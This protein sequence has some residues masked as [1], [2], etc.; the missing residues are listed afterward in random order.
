MRYY[1]YIVRC[2]GGS[3][4]TGITTDPQRR[5]R[6]HVLHLAP[7]AKYTKSHQVIALDAL[8]SAETRSEASMLEAA[9]K[10]LR[11]EKKRQLIE[12]PERLAVF[13]GARLDTSIYRAEATFSLAPLLAQ[14]GQVLPHG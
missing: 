11:P 2:E 13:L 3:H 10:R 4:Y 5:M 9:I 6:E 12:S 8:W 7:G 14:A 1:I